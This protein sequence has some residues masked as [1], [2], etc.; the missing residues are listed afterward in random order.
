[1]SP[2]LYS[3]LEGV[4]RDAEHLFGPFV[5]LRSI[6]SQTSQLGLAHGMLLQDAVVAMLVQCAFSFE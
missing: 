2:V 4:S 5:P 6:S 1:M 3:S